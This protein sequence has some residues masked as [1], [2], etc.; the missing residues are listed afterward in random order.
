[1]RFKFLPL[2]GFLAAAACFW[3]A[4]SRYPGGYDLNRHYFSTLLRG[5][6][7]PERIPA[8]A[9]VLIYCASIAVVFVR[10][11]RAVGSSRISNVI[12]IAGIGSMVYSSLVITPMHDLMVTISIPFFVVAML[13]LLWVHYERRIIG[14][15]ITGIVCFVLLLTSVTIYYSGHF[16][17]VL[18]WAQ[19]TL[20][21]LFAIW[22]IS[23]DL[24]APRLRLVEKRIS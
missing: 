11:A 19:R 23:L 16:V 8:I 7:G 14:F 1:M 17:S 5:V 21:A 15:L 22:L 6:P 2:F 13:A 9:G 24:R 4:A 20:F 18:P 12:R 10:L 3:V